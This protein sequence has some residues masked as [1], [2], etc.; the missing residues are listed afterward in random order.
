MQKKHDD[1]KAAALNP[2]V[3]R[4]G[5]SHADAVSRNLR[6]F[7]AS[8]MDAESRKDLN[9]FINQEV[10]NNNG[11]NLGPIMPAPVLNWSPEQAAL[12]IYYLG[13]GK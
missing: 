5:E 10:N 2:Y 6:D 13:P 12:Q 7:D 1:Q 9:Q 11:I 4:A 3:L 8:D